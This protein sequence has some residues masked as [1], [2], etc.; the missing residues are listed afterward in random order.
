MNALFKYELKSNIKALLIW[1]LAV[2]GMGLLCIVLYSSMEVSMEEMA[3]SMA[4]MGA[5]SDAFGMSTLS[6]ATLKGYFAT[7]IGAIHS[8]GS[9]MFAASIAAV[10][11]S[12]EEDGHTAEFTFTLPVSRIKII[13]AKYVSV[14]LNLVI[15]TV[16]CAI[17]YGVGFV[18]LGEEMPDKEFSLF[19]GLQLMMNV[20]VAAIC[21]LLSAFSKKN[22]LGMGISLAMILYAFDIMFRVIPDMKDIMFITPF[23]YANASEIFSNADLNTAGIVLSILLIVGFTVLSALI[24]NKKD[25]AS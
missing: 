4:G 17:L 11:L 24:Y 25:L 21:F 12:K 15:F 10:A 1:S 9:S 16:I 19:M 2:G 7:E 20:E 22:K 18:C 8:L 3:E 13:A 23:S 14:V 6:I 5:L